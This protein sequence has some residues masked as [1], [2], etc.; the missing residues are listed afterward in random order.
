MNPFE[1][2]P[3]KIEKLFLSWNDMTPAPYDKHSVDPYTKTRI[4]LM[5]GTE[6][7]AVWF[8]H[9]F[10]RHCMD[11]DLRRELALIRRQEQQQQ[12]LI[13]ALKPVEETILEHTIGYEQLAVDLTAALAQREKNPYVKNALD[14]ALLE[15]VKSSIRAQ[16]KVGC[17]GCRYCMPCPKGV[18]IPGTFS[19]Y[20]TMYIDSKGVGRKQFIQ[21]VGLTKEPAFA[22]QC[23]ECGKCE[24]HCPQNLPIREKLKEADRALRPLHYRIAIQ[25]ARKF[26]YRKPAKS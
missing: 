10:A 25:V 3:G 15:E 24:Q 21:T 17:T 22:S 2:K 6:F 18:D 23:V 19:C 8:S 1:L 7:E 13:G 9:Q 20:N 26:M 16:E 12:K 11:N 14:F 5:N 4:I